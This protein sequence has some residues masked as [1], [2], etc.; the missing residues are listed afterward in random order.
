MLL[1]LIRHTCLRLFV[2]RQNLAKDVKLEKH[3]TCIVVFMPGSC[4][5]RLHAMRREGQLLLLEE[6]DCI[7]SGKAWV[8]SDTCQQGAT[9]AKCQGQIKPSCSWHSAVDLDLK[10]N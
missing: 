7:S 4:L 10:G 1:M 9:S 5:A 8:S 2:T 6:R 3:V